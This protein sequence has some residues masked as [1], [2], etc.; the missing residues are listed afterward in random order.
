MISILIIS[1]IAGGIICIC[2]YKCQTK[3]EESRSSLESQTSDESIK[4]DDD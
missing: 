3:S 2:K 1:I 4:N